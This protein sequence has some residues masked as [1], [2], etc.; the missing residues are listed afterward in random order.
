M[1]ACKG[2]SV[3]PD[4]STTNSYCAFSPIGS[5]RAIGRRVMFLVVKPVLDILDPDHQTAVPLRSAHNIMPGILHHQPDIILLGKAYPR[6]DMVRL[7]RIY[8]V[9]RHITQIT[10]RERSL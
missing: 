10:Q 7:G 3:V 9:H 8:G 6:R 5:T 1:L 4:I 2:I